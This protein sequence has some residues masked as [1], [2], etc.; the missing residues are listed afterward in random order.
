[1]ATEDLEF[2]NQ[3]SKEEKF[4]KKRLAAVGSGS[5]VLTTINEHDRWK[6]CKVY[7]I[8]QILY[9]LIQTKFCKRGSFGNCC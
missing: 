7:E 9:V 1:M 3:L 8:A 4:E 5:M 6:H 2:K